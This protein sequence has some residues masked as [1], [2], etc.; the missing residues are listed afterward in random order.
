MNS[1]DQPGPSNRPRPATQNANA[2][3][4]GQRNGKPPGERVSRSS[5]SNAN[6]E[7]ALRL[8]MISK[9]MLG[10]HLQGRRRISNSRINQ[11]QHQLD[12]NK[13]AWA[14]STHHQILEVRVLKTPR[15]SHHTSSHNLHLITDLHHIRTN[16]WF[17]HLRLLLADLDRVRRDRVITADKGHKCRLVSTRE[18][19]TR[20]WD[21]REW[22]QIQGWDIDQEGEWG[23][24]QIRC[25]W[26]SSGSIGMAMWKKKTMDHL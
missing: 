18:H 24:D 23:R 16:L 5:F 4:T 20:E 21:Q 22:I 14:S 25:I 12:L 19:L 13:K 11:D 7:Q 8:S 3:H 9:R 17:H 10:L 6:G 15:T 2:N 26:G 1:S